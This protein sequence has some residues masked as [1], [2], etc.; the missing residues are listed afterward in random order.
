MISMSKLDDLQSTIN[1]IAQERM[2]VKIEAVIQALST[3]Y[4]LMNELLSEVRQGASDLSVVIAKY[5]ELDN[6]YKQLQAVAAS[7]AARIAEVQQTIEDLEDNI[8]MTFELMQQAV[9]EVASLKEKIEEQSKQ[10]RTVK[11][12]AFV[13][14]VVSVLSL[15]L[16]VI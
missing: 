12:L 14:V 15:I 8:D 11:I 10:L 3:I 5:K 16:R 7:Y 13:S 6:D 2:D 1:S 9:E 4:D